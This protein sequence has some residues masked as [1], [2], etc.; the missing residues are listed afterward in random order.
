MAPLKIITLNVANSLVLGGLLSI[1][2]V[3]NPDIVLLQELTLTS[4][5]LKLYVAKFG[6]S[7]EANTDLMDITKL[8]TGIIWKTELPVSEVTSVIECRGQ[9]AKLGPYNLLNLYAPSGGNNKTAR[10]NF[11]GQDVFHLIRGLGSSPYPILAGDFNCVLSAKDTE[12]NFGDKKCPA[13]Q[14]LVSGFNLSD[15][16]RVVKPD[17]SEFTFHRPNCA[18][19]RLDRFYIPQEFVPHIKQV[20]HHAS[21]GDHHYVVFVVDLPDLEVLPAPPKSSPLYWKLNTSILDDEDFLE[22]FETVYQKVQLKISEYHDIASWW[23]LLAKPTIREFCMDVSERFSFVR[24][25]SKRFLFSYLT[26]VIKRGDWGEV[27]RVRKKLESLLLKESMGVI[28]RSRHKEHVETEKASLFFLNRENKN[29]KKGSLSDLKIDDTETSDKT[30]IEKEVLKYFGALFNGHHDRQGKDTGQPFIPD[31]SGLPVFL[32]DLAGLSQESQ[33][34]LTKPLVYKNIKNIIFKECDHNKS[35]GL[36]GLPY[37]FYQATWNIIGHDFVKVL[38]VQLDRISLIESDRHGATRLASKVD[39][40]PAVNELRPITLLNCDYKILSKSFVRRMVPIMREVICSGQLC[41]VEDMNIL[42]GISNIISA[43]DY[44]NAH[45]IAA[46]LVSLDMFKAY[47]RVMLDYLVKVMAAMR[48]PEKFIKWILMLHEGATTS[49]LLSFLT[50]PIGIFFSIRQG[51]PLSMLLYI[52]YIEGLFMSN[53]VQKDEAYC[54][55]LIFF[56]SQNMIC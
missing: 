1:I 14:D 4:G 10:R 18:A 34:N 31:Y 5:Q 50:K 13:L 22:N 56:L 52:I 39:G 42:F 38:Q 53:F 45:S 36:D 16:F 43:I 8:G 33:D 12:R 24:K 37:E 19:S 32:E 41:S 28:V 30:K 47:D 49:F 44:V 48:F 23:D 46:F 51:D 2:R 20:S 55:D 40:V 3:E 9:L 27:S 7:A 54:D 15:A 17:V 29:Y 26:L 11:F 35:P 25:N 6:Y 21:L